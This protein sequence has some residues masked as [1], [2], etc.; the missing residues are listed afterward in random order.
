MNRVTNRLRI[1]GDDR[2]KK[3]VKDAELLRTS[4]PNSLSLFCICEKNDKNE[5]RV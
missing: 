3:W 5:G 2:L 4:K 1:A